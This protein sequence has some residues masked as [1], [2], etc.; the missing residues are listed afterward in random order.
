MGFL[1][2]LTKLKQT[3]PGTRHSLP[4]LAPMPNGKRSPCQRLSVAWPVLPPTLSIPR[5]SQMMACCNS[6][7]V[8]AELSLPATW[9]ATASLGFI[10]SAW[11]R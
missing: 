10:R 11:S 9:S 3:L 8:F 1:L 4:V 5:C 6:M 7:L 2:N